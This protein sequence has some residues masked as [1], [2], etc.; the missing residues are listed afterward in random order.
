MDVHVLFVDI[1][2]LLSGVMVGV[3]HL[4]ELVGLEESC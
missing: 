4:Q 1:S 3:F 2:Q